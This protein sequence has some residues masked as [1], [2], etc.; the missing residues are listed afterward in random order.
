MTEHERDVEYLDKLIRRL[1]DDEMFRVVKILERFAAR[2]RNG[3][4]LN[5]KEKTLYW[6]AHGML[7]PHYRLTRD[8]FDFKGGKQ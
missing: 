6:E 2:D 4:R 5:E 7:P 8:K 1:S 3:P